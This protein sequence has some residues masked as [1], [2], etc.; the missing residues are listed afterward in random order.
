MPPIGSNPSDD[1]GT[2]RARVNFEKVFEL[3]PERYLLIDADAPRFTMLAA[4][5]EYLRLVMMEREA[6]VG[7]GVFEVFPETATN[8][9]A[10]F[11]EALEAVVH[12][13]E[14]RSL[15]AYRFDMPDRDVP[16][17]LFERYRS[18]SLMPLFGDD[19]QVS[20]VL[21][22]VEEATDF[23]L[24]ERYRYAAPPAPT[25][26]RRSAA[27][28]CSSSPTIAGGPTSRGPSRLTGRSRPPSALRRP[29]TPSSGSA[30]TPS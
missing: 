9:Q 22:R 27:A 29:S 3:T 15:A 6:L 23:V 12:E 20:G 2:A 11:R 13:G 5:E 24:R 7:R 30:P 19:G 1:A 14:P 25:T 28:C 17:R 16:D 26:A 18:P 21:L 4:S 8:E 10:R